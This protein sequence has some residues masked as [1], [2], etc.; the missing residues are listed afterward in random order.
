MS[1]CIY[2]ELG[3]SDVYSKTGYARSGGLV[4][5]GAGIGSIGRALLAL[6]TRNPRFL[7]L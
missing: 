7:T 5:A 6:G 1:Y 4:K 3:G 2:R